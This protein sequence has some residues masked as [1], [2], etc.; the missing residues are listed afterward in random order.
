LQPLLRFIGKAAAKWRLV[1]V[2]LEF[3]PDVL[4][5]IEQENGGKPVNCFTALLSRWLKRAPHKYSL[6]TLET[7]V[8]ALRENTV[9]EYRVA[10]SLE[11]DFQRTCTC[12]NHVTLICGT[13]TTK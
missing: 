6:P 2:A 8:R 9:E 11:Q 10:Y 7:L 4:N 12:K 3:Q 13:C 5:I 1:G